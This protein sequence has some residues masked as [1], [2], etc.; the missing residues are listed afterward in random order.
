MH[1][2]RMVM[3]HCAEIYDIAS[4]GRIS[5]PNTLPSEVE[6]VMEEVHQDEIREAV[7]EARRDLCDALR[8]LASFGDGGHTSDGCSPIYGCRCGLHDALARASELVEPSPAA[9]E[10]EAT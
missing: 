10:G 9:S 3:R 5:K 2:F 1:D 6:S 7:D 8:Q 4:H